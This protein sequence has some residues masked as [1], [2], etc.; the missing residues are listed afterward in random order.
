MDINQL[1]NETTQK[2]SKI[3]DGLTR[4]FQN[5]R[6][7][8]AN[9]NILDHIMIDYY[10]TPTPVNQA[11]SV[12]VPEPQLITIVP[13][14]KKL[15]SEIEKALLKADIGITP[16]NDGNSIRLPIPPLNEERRKEMVKKTKKVAE[17]F[18]T[19]VRNTRR[20]FLTKLKE[21]GKNKE[22]S[23]DDVTRQ[24]DELQKKTNNYIAKIDDM[25]VE[26]EKELMEI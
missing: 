26:K 21:S 18:K 3:I 25:M 15:L 24:S 16:Q 20:D 11:G 10:G 6:T 13:W 17:D 14:E 9:P 23:E 4:E 22:L 8:R 2:M 5:I 1:D 19:T 7:G 12:T